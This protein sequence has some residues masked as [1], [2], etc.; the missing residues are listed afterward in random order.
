[1]TQALVQNPTPGV[2]VQPDLLPDC[3]LARPTGQKWTPA[4]WMEPAFCAACHR[5]G[6]YVPVGMTFAFYLHDECVEKWGR[7]AALMYVPDEVAIA[8]H[9]E[10]RREEASR[11]EEGR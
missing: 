8:R 3:R 2:L 5:P 7:V 6:P 4:G 1:M 10:A 9:L 11:T